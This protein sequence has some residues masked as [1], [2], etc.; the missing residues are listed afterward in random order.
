MSAH[1]FQSDSSTLVLLT[2]FNAFLSFPAMHR[3]LEHLASFA[4]AKLRNKSCALFGCDVRPSKIFKEQLPSTNQDILAH[5]F[6]I[7]FFWHFLHF[8]ASIFL[9][10]W[11]VVVLCQYHSLCRYTSR[12]GW[13]MRRFPGGN[14]QDVE[15][16][17]LP[18]N[19]MAITN[20]TQ[21]PRLH[22]LEPQQYQAYISYLQGWERDFWWH[23]WMCTLLM[24]ATAYRFGEVFT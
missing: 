23:H 15:E 24:A 7:D 11:S 5:T 3:V 19:F 9:K 12:C 8:P 17:K 10:I 21:C 13:D 6:W 22:R 2:S 18:I 16:C 4:M 20:L 14:V 1:G